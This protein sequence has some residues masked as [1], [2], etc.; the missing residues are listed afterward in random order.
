MP[1]N[2]DS[3]QH[4]PD[5]G[6]TTTIVL[7]EFAGLRS[8][9]A[10]RVNLL[11]TVILG[12]LTVLGVVFGI[13]LGRSG[14]THILLVLALVTPSI[15]LLYLDQSRELENL[16]VCMTNISARSSRSPRSS[17]STM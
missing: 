17:R 5:P 11:V 7:A 6:R 12:N 2:N 9:I 1:G 10:T 3:D 4:D 13:A 16:G 15:G 14:N 8:E